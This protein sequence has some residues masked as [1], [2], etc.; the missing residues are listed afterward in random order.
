MSFKFSMNTLNIVK[1]FS[2]INPGMVFSPGKILQ[3]LEPTKAILAKAEI[4]EEI[5]GEFAISDLSRFL[6][7]LSMHDKETMELK[8]EPNKFVEILS[9]DKKTTIYRTTDKSNIVYP[10]KQ[11]KMPEIVAQYSLSAKIISDIIS[12]A[13][14]LGLPHVVFC[15][16]EVLIKDVKDS[17][18]DSHKICIPHLPPGN[19][20]ATFKIENF[21]RLLKNVSYNMYLA[22]KVSHFVSEDGKLEYYI[23]LEKGN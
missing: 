17:S 1:N 23:A 15:G 6:G 11:L 12:D 2:T 18:A 8:V 21:S 10:Q 20:Q 4:E 3:T 22:E 9:G 5:P 13:A 7:V 14:S 16:N 19:F